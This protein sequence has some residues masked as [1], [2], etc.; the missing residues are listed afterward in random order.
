MYW[1]LALVISFS[2]HPE[3]HYPGLQYTFFFHLPI[4]F[5]KANNASASNNS[6]F[7]SEAVNDLLKRSS[8]K[9]RLILDVRHVRAFVYKQ[10]LSVA[11]QIFNKDYRLFK[12]DPR[13]CLG[14]WHWEVQ[15]LSILRSSVWPFFCPFYTKILKPLQK[16]WRS[17][18]IPID[19]YHA[20][21][22][23]SPR[24]TE[25]FVFARLASHWM[26]G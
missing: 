24:G 4:P 17:R 3:C 8:G 21:A 9:Q 15:I 2:V 22:I 10:K 14:L 13:I 1:F 23:L 18:G 25:S 19:L 7:V 11:T 6:T 20:A 16:S 5:S 26:R 12:F